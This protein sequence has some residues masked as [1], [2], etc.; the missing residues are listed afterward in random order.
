MWMFYSKRP[1]TTQELQHALAINTACGRPTAQ[2]VDEVDVILE[3]C[4]NLLMEENN[5]LRPIHYSVQEFFK[6]APQGLFEGSILK[7]LLNPSSI[8]EGLCLFCLK[9]IT[10]EGFDRRCEQDFSLFVRT[11]SAPFARYAAQSFDYHALHCKSSEIIL[12][13]IE[14][15]LCQDSGFLAAIL[16]IR[17]MRS[18][19]DFLSISLHFDPISFPVSASTVLYETHLYDIP[20]LQTRWIGHTPPK[21]ALHSASSSGL[22]H[23]V[24][25]LVEQGC[26]VNEI[27]EKG[28][29]SVYYAS[30]EGYDK[31]V[32]LLLSKGADVNAQHGYYGNSLQA[33]SYGGHDKIVEVLL[34][35]GADIY[36]QGGHYG[37]ALQAAS[38]GGNDKIM[39]VL[40]SKGADINAQGGYYGNALQAASFGGNDKI[41]ELLLNKG[42]DI[43][44]QGGDFGN[45]LQAA[46]SRGYDEIVELL[47]SKGADINAQGG[48]YGNALQAALGA[49][50]H[51]IAEVLRSKGAAIN[52]GG[53]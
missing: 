13:K 21:Y 35:K 48:R 16:Q 12:Q 25:R 18:G 45:A 3:A 5:A 41:V 7:R 32:E 39:E 29:D 19:S 20:R 9:Y 42:A 22:V 49:R 37:N 33:A 30:R 23:A 11:Q 4:G 44:A 53:L 34:S 8:H 15:L 46:S 31:I 50:H 10:F 28:V 1:L 14:E 38:A 17:K 27:D 24:N 40:L 51:T 26:D 47:L 43:N 52:G 36:A 2:Q 6:N